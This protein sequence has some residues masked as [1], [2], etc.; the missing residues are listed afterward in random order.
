MNEGIEQKPAKLQALLVAKPEPGHE[1]DNRVVINMHLYEWR[2]A[3]AKI[4]N[5]R[6]GELIKLAK[7]VHI[8]PKV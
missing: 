3:P 6:I 8:R 5:V 1:K 2:R 7:I 4:R